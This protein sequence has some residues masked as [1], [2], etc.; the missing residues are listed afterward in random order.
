MEDLFQEEGYLPGIIWGS[1]ISYLSLLSGI[2]H[3]WEVDLIWFD[4]VWG[5]LQFP[6]CQQWCWC[7]AGSG[8]CLQNDVWVSRQFTCVPVTLRWSK[9]SQEQVWTSRKFSPEKESFSTGARR[10]K[11]SQATPLG[12]QSLQNLSFP[13]FWGTSGDAVRQGHGE[14]VRGVCIEH[15]RPSPEKSEFVFVWIVPFSLAFRV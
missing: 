13:E 15:A 1:L 7:L 12:A 8:G 11:G 6:E 10:C 4:L 14:G 3:L 2:P 9:T 5:G